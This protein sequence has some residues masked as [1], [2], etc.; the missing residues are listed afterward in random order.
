MHLVSREQII[1]N[2]V[3]YEIQNTHKWILFRKQN[4]GMLSQKLQTNSK[5][6]LLNKHL[7]IENIVPKMWTFYTKNKLC[8][9]RKYAKIDSDVSLEISS[10]CNNEYN[11]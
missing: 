11:L 8:P 4:A 9:L 7:F 5:N 2:P 10:S 1:K 3:L 6:G